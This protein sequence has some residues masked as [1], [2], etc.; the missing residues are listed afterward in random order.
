M[1]KSALQFQTTSLP[2]HHDV[3]APDSSQIRVLLA[4]SRGSMAHGTLPPGG[5]SRAVVHRTV[6]EIWFVLDGM[7]EIWRR[8]G[9]HAAVITAPPGTSLTIPVGTHFQFR[10]LG[11]APFRFLMCTMP[12]WPGADEAVRVPD[13]W[14]V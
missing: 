14:P 10:T 8:Q 6:E 11:D 1:T 3:L 7:A 13:F 2:D 12:P 5:V 4:T 9:D